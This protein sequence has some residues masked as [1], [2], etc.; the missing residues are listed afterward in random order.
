[1]HFKVL[2]F[3]NQ[4]LILLAFMAAGALTRV[5]KLVGEKQLN[6]LSRILIDVLVPCL[7]LSSFIKKFS[8][9]MLVSGFFVVLIALVVGLA[10]YGFGLL[11]RRFL[12][13][14]DR[15][16]K[17]FPALCFLGNTSFLPIPL[18]FSLY[19]SH[20]LL[21]V[22]L[23]DFGSALLVWTIGISL[24]SAPRV[25]K[26]FAQFVTPGFV[27]TLASV[28]LVLLSLNTAVPQGIVQV[29]GFA[30]AVTIP[31][32]LLMIG[33]LLSE[34]F[35]E[36]QFNAPIAYACFIKLV[37]VPALVLLLLKI[38][39]ASLDPLMKT[40]ILL[41]AAMPVM[42]SSAVFAK[43]FG[44]DTRLA[45][46]AVFYSTLFSFLTVPFFLSLMR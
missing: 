44:G 3:Y 36:K 25:K 42:S 2:A 10:G 18:V 8:R 24:F 32:A 43:R 28:A 26:S 29:M 34:A 46:S 38:F 6:I 23:Y 7:I 30:G 31:I 22:F 5:T 33:W 11:S 40:V 21:Y 17:M 27:S 45:S 35:G 16:N 14:E 4:L 15:L 39:C 37:F 20:A 19:G 13:R 41:E 12:P 1:M 9:D